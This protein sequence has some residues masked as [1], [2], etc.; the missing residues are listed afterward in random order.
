M[1]RKNKTSFHKIIFL[2]LLLINQTALCQQPLLDLSKALQY[3]LNASQTTRKAAL[4]AENAVYKNEEARGKAMPQI[5]ATGSMN[6]NPILQLTALPGELAGQPGKTLLIAFGQKWN[7]GASV[8]LSQSLFD[9]ST[10]VR[11]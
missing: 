6:Y 5:S 1:S 4:D 11:I 8:A 2:L 7:T 9:K 3:A 10:C